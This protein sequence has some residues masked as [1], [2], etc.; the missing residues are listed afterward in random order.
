LADDEANVA[1]CT[2]AYLVFESDEELMTGE[3]VGL[4][5]GT[6]IVVSFSNGM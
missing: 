3:A 1:V 6:A 5:I 4:Y 2:A